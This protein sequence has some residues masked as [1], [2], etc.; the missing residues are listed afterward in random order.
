MHLLSDPW[1][2][3]AALFGVVLVGVSKG[4]SSGSA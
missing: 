2:V 4:G 1:F 3:A